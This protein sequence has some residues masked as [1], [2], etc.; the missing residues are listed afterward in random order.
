MSDEEVF[1]VTYELPSGVRRLRLI[2][3]QLDAPLLGKELAIAWVALARHNANA[4]PSLRTAIPRFCTIVARQPGF[5]PL[6]D[7]LEDL[8][9]RHLDAWE[10][11]LLDDQA[12]RGT[13]FPYRLAIYLSALLRWIE[14]EQPGRLHP[15]VVARTAEKTRLTPADSH[16]LEEF[17]KRELFHIRRAALELLKPMEEKATSCAPDTL[18][19]LHILL[20]L[21]T[22]Q[23][24]EVLRVLTM[25]DVLAATT[26]QRG[27]DMDTA[28]LAAAGLATSY[29]VM[30][31]KWRAHSSTEETFLR[32]RHARIVRLLDDLISRTNALRERSSLRSLWLTVNSRGEIRRPDWS[33]PS[34]SDWLKKYV[35]EEISRPHDW[36]RFRKSSIARDVIDNT[37]TFLATQHRH[38]PATFF[39]NYTASPS[40]RSHLRK[41]WG[42][43]AGD[44]HK[45]AMGPTVVVD[46]EVVRTDAANQN[47]A[48]VSS[49]DV[50]LSSAGGLTGCIA[51]EQSP[52][53]KEG[54]AC[55]VSRA[56][57]CFTCPNAVITAEHLPAIVL[58]NE[59]TS[60]DA[61]A[62]FSTWSS[63]WSE[64][65]DSTNTIL[66]LF[67]EAS[68]AEARQHTP[69]VL[70]DLG[71]RQGLRGR[72]LD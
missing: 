53:A 7:G 8:R 4:L 15:S 27:A 10:R 1:I 59:I 42:Q 38:S 37:A 66:S 60:P 17:S 32:K 5:D 6:H 62:S 13:E 14:D 12:E 51:P 71:L 56:G 22:A 23:P 25:D 61:A 39:D 49:A 54:E 29:S 20:S 36:R 44:M 28:A 70:V 30:M 40:M 64:I 43:T 18:I 41:L 65:H 58:F 68:V 67:P 52:Y 2:P 47:I 57:K 34:L 55:P 31:H 50:P 11:V 24:P 63:V 9:R 45:R 46:G 72:D 35:K 19:A 3:A 33:Q 48:I 26:D 21:A 16:P 69:E